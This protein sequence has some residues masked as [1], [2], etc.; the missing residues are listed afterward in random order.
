MVKGKHKTISNRSQYMWASSE[1]SSPTIAS[2]EY[3]NT[4]ENQESVL[5]FYLMKIIGSF[6]E[7]IHNSLKEIQENTGK[8]V[9]VLKEET[10]PLKKYRKTQS[11]RRSNCINR[12]KT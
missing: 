3:T 6:K 11:N 4:P 12:F 1:P 2:S 5:K 9:E 10:N 7:D 8:Q